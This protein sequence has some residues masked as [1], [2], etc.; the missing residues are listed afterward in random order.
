MNN[1]QSSLCAKHYDLLRVIWFLGWRMALQ[2]QL[3]ELMVSLSA[4]KS[5]QMCRRGIRALRDAQLLKSKYWVDGKSQVLVICKP[6]VAYITNRTP[7][8]FSLS[9]PSTSRGPEWSSI[10]RLWYAQ[11]LIQNKGL[12]SYEALRDLVANTR[13]TLY[14]HRSELPDYWDSHRNY[15]PQG[16]EYETQ[17]KAMKIRKTPFDLPADEQVLRT[18]T[19]LC[20]LHAHGLFLIGRIRGNRKY[21]PQKLQF[22]Y[23]NWNTLSPKKAVE[24][25]CLCMEWAR[26]L[27]QNYDIEL[28][29]FC[30]NSVQSNTLTQQLSKN[31]HGREFWE[32]ASNRW[33]DGLLESPIY[34]VDT[35]LDQTYLKSTPV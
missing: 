3:V 26:S 14:C 29:V 15:F 25:A 13:L 17:R 24:L 7:E 27:D 33:F 1:T 30:R 9:F 5:Q 34:L 20:T 22:G 18:Y 10:F 32:A 12:S 4:Y 11:L 28:L 19:T 16:R 6:A 21:H 2:P 8:I 23:F 31:V 35:K